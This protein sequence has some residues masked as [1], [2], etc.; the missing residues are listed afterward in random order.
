MT[1]AFVTIAVAFI[2]GGPLVWWLDRR[3]TRQ[4]AKGVDILERMDDKVD[5]LHTKVGRLDGK[6]D[7]LDARLDAHIGP[8]GPAPR[9]R[10]RK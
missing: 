4:H 9:K 7:R 1:Q 5:R 8:T 10:V 3:N 2:A 6:V